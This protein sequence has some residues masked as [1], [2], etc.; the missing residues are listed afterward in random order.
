MLVKS[1]VAF[2]LAI[3][4]LREISESRT[5]QVMQAEPRV[6]SAAPCGKHGRSEPLK[7]KLAD[8]SGSVE[9]GRAV[10]K[11]SNLQVFVHHFLCF[12]YQLTSGPTYIFRA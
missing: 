7:R 11:R 12:T 9:L 5:G 3:A 10:A 2:M 1:R 4:L 6:T 8:R